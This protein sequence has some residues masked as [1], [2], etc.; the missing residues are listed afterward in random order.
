MHQCTAYKKTMASRQPYR[1][2]LDV[3]TH[4]PRTLQG[5][6]NGTERT[7]P[8]QGSRQHHAEQFSTRQW[9]CASGPIGLAAFGPPPPFVA[10]LASPGV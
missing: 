9:G 5:A 2:T 4:L 1:C 3:T 10:K 8:V 6:T 7:Q